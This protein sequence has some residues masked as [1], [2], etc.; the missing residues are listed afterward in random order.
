MPGLPIYCRIHRIGHDAALDAPGDVP[1]KN[2]ERRLGALHRRP[3]RLAVDCPPLA[4][5]A[6]GALASVPFVM[7]RK[8]PAYIVVSEPNANLSSEHIVVKYTATPPLD[9]WERITSRRLSRDARP[10]LG[11]DAR[12]DPGECEQ[13]A[14]S[15][16]QSRHALD[17]EG[18]ERGLGARV[19][20]GRTGRT[21]PQTGRRRWRRESRPRATSGEDR[22]EGEGRVAA[23][24][25]GPRTMKTATRPEAEGCRSECPGRDPPRTE[26]GCAPRDPSR[27]PVLFPLQLPPARVGGPSC[28]PRPRRAPRRWRR[29]SDR[30]SPWPLILVPPL[31]SSRSQTSQQ[32][33]P[34][35]MSSHP[36][37]SRLVASS[38]GRAAHDGS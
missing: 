15:A 21:P 1:V 32:V 20:A 30:G 13:G 14:G 19:G 2:D 23:E 3:S 9:G 28:P 29:S 17:R 24:R 31:L 36:Q 26:G 8:G 27:G 7:G 12:T 38:L 4:L 25:S 33:V 6:P 11:G 37:P 10:P 18:E 35:R 22:H 34:R 5:L 16:E